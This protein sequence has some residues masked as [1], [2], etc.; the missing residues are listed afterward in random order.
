[1]ILDGLWCAPQHHAFPP[2][3]E[4]GTGEVRGDAKRLRRFCQS[5]ALIFS[6]KS[7]EHISSRSKELFD[8]NP[9]I[10]IET[11]RR[12]PISKLT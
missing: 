11:K 3:L 9:K 10:T 6:L 7:F 8:S 2:V 1:M 5:K 12:I 4:E